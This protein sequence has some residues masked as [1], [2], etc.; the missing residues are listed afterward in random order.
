MD[1]V[2]SSA[3]AGGCGGN[4]FSDE[5]GVQAGAEEGRTSLRTGLVDFLHIFG[6]PV[7]GVG[8]P[9]DADNILARCQQTADVFVVMGIRGLDAGAMENHIGIQRE[10][11]INIAS[12]DN[13][14]GVTTCNVS[15]ILS[16]LGFSVHKEPDQVQVRVIDD[17]PQT[18][19]SHGPGG[20]LNDF[21]IHDDAKYL[22]RINRKR[23]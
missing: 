14:C 10:N 9:I 21:V 20:P 8:V 23:T 12:G 3:N 16:H 11:C 19:F 7:L 5:P 1:A 6:S 4:F 15:R 18:G 13:A 17:C 22:T 2:D